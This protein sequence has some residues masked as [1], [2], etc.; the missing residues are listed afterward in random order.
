MHVLP[1]LFVA[2]SV[3]Q[4][5]QSPDDLRLH[6]GETFFVAGSSYGVYSGVVGHA[7][8]GKYGRVLQWDDFFATVSR[9]DLQVRYLERRSTRNALLVAGFICMGAGVATML[10][11]ILTF[12]TREARYTTDA[13]GNDSSIPSD[14]PPAYTV[15]MIAGGGALAI[16]GTVV[17]FV[18]LWYRTMDVPTHEVRA[19]VD[20][21][22]QKLG[23]DTEEKPSTRSI[24]VQVTPAFGPNYAGAAMAMTY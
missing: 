23:D 1:L 3:F 22:N 7:S 8:Q 15:P 24:N 14:G 9:P 17:A 16:A 21:F 10:G 6:D 13:F 11:G 20:A 2:S 18:G 12:G 4:A 5:S 19:M